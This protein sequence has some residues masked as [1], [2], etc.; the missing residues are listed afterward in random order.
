MTETMNM[1]ALFIK[2]L[3]I[4]SAADWPS[5]NTKDKFKKQFYGFVL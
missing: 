1:G 3:F 2:C 5:I 4:K